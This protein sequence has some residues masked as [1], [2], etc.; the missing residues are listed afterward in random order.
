M[1]DP[2][3][4]RIADELRMEIESGRL[5]RGGQ[6]PT[7]LELRD[8]YGASRNT[9]RDAIKLLISLG[10][11]ESRPGQGTFVTEHI[12]PFVTSLTEDPKTGFG[13]SDGGAYLFKEGQHRRSE[14]SEPRVEIQLGAG[15]VSNFLQVKEGT[16]LVSR[17]Q[18]RF[19]DGTPWSLQTSF[20][21]ISFALEGATR[22][23]EAMNIEQGTIRY[24]REAIGLEQK[25]YRDWITMRSPDA[26]EMNFFRLSPDGRVPLV[27]IFRTA[28]DQNGK[29]MRLTITLFPADRNQFVISVG[30]MPQTT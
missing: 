12:E 10:L 4:R 23:L 1:A 17:H 9:I 7:E 19:I 6:L 24:L 29:P 28:F 15:L 18:Q 13:G 21:P 11:V 27:E 20:Y 2:M 8:Q 16:Q 30:D 14:A 25:G 3:Y 26:A 5:G 22:L